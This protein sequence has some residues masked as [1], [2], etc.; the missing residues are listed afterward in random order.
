MKENQLK[1]KIFSLSLLEDKINGWLAE[2]EKVEN[3]EAV[4]YREVKH[5][6]V[7][8]NSYIIIWYVINA[9]F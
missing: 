7:I 3:G 6:T 9:P 5:T 1:A 2:P 4:G 8:S